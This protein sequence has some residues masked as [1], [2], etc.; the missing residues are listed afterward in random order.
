MKPQSVPTTIIIGL[1]LVAV[2][3]GGL[4]LVGGLDIHKTKP[5]AEEKQTKA[6]VAAPPVTDC[7]ESREIYTAVSRTE[8]V[9]PQ[10]DYPNVKC[11]TTTKGVLWYGDPFDGTIPIGEMP[12]IS[13][14]T[15]GDFVNA[16]VKP[17]EPRL[18]YY[19]PT[20]SQKFG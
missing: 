6:E 18:T 9:V 3:A 16:V 1:A 5:S 10:Y 8:N 12:K 17:R 7:F 11:S 15:Q 4:A 14:E 2:F 19:K 20:N 13:D